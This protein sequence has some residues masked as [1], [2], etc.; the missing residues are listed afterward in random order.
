METG[1]MASLALVLA[2]GAGI[3]GLGV[4]AMGQAQCPQSVRRA[5]DPGVT[6]TVTGM[7]E[8]CL[9]IGNPFSLS[10]FTPWHPGMRCKTPFPSH[11]ATVST[12]AEGPLISHAGAMSV[13]CRDYLHDGSQV[14]ASRSREALLRRV[15]N[16]VTVSRTHILNSMAKE[17]WPPPDPVLGAEMVSIDTVL[18]EVPALETRCWRLA[19]C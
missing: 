10:V 16:L 8:H 4:E 9:F 12:V 17:W 5:R 6:G 19:F 18:L 2:L 15:Y 1:F 13:P 3:C 7:A 11:P 14:N